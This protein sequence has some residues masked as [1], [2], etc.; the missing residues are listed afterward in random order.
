[1]QADSWYEPNIDVSTFWGSNACNGKRV[2]I[3]PYA[4]GASDDS[5]FVC[6][7]YR[8]YD[9]ITVTVS[10]STDPKNDF[11][12]K[13]VPVP[14]YAIVNDDTILVAGY[15]ANDPWV[16]YFDDAQTKKFVYGPGIEPEYYLLRFY[17]VKP[18]G[19]LN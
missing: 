7:A 6:K 19:Q 16:L 9:P 10:G 1:M 15:I 3:T 8:N 17:K 5:L 11:K 2:T 13:S 12:N 4:T 18:Y 14:G